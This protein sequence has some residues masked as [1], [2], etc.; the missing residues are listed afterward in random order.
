MTDDLSKRW[1]TQVELARTAVETAFQSADDMADRI[2]ELEAKLTKAIGA[3]R[4]YAHGLRNAGLARAVL[5][6]LEV[7][8]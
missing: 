5:A 2:E 7:K 6:E 8:E 4:C 1:D 3:L